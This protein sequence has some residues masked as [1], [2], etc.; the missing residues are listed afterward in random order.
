MAIQSLGDIGDL[1]AIS[2]CYC[3]VLTAAFHVEGLQPK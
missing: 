2:C 1:L 3:G